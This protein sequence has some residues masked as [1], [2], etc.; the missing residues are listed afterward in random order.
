MWTHLDNREKCGLRLTK[1]FKIFIEQK[2]KS[3]FHPC[4]NSEPSLLTSEDDTGL[5]TRRKAW[6]KTSKQSIGAVNIKLKPGRRKRTRRRSPSVDNDTVD[7]HD[8][9]VFTNGESPNLSETIH[10]SPKERSDSFSENNTGDEPY[11]RPGEVLRKFRKHLKHSSAS[12]TSSLQ[13]IGNLSTDSFF[14]NVELR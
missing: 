8:S 10:S 9:A 12:E 11:E 13:T 2:I 6:K 1:L 14:T 7:S 5:G 3:R 4:F